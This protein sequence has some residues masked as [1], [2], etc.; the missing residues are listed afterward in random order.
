MLVGVKRSFILPAL[1]ILVFALSRIPGMLPPNFSAAYAFVFCAGVYFPKRMAWWL[2]LGT[3]IITDIALN[4][5]YQSL[6]WNVWQWSTLRYQLFNYVAYGVL[7]WLG[8]RFKPRS[9]FVSLLGGGIFGAFF[10]YLITNT[11]S[12][13]VNPFANPEYSKTFWGWITA[14]VTG[15]RNWPQTWEFFRSTL[16]SGGLF[17]AL[18]V[19]AMKLTTPAESPL[20]KE[21]GKREEEAEGESEPEEAKV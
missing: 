2:P 15:T 18:F 6:G 16:L 10:F 7:I 8:Q 13:L 3:L 1:L 14:L 19:A 17:T 11:I 4:F 12:W 5:Y 21:A 9:S 20:E